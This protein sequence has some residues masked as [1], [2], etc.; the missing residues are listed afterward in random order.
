MQ[1]RRKPIT[2]CRATPACPGKVLEHGAFCVDHE[3]L[4][5]AKCGEPSIRIRTKHRKMYHQFQRQQDRAYNAMEYERIDH[6]IRERN[7]RLDRS[8]VEINK[9][10]DLQMAQICNG[11]NKLV[12]GDHVHDATLYGLSQHTPVAE[13]RDIV[14]VVD[15]G[16][17]GRAALGDWRLSTSAHGAVEERQPEVSGDELHRSSK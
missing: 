15:D 13:D 11:I 9:M 17:E 1:T 12:G 7:A 10:L 4:W 6:M 3:L 5:I 16:A 2:Q 8:A 14:L